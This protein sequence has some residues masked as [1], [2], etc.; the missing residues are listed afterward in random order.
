MD[1]EQDYYGARRIAQYK[2]NTNKKQLALAIEEGNEDKIH[3][4]ERNIKLYEDEIKKIE[5]GV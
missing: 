3:K 4:L 2:L 1:N 5:K